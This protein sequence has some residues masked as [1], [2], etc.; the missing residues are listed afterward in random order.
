MY[1]SWVHNRAVD[2]NVFVCIKMRWW[3]KR[4]KDIISRVIKK[5]DIIWQK[6]MRYSFDV[7]SSFYCEYLLVQK[8]GL[9][10]MNDSVTIEEEYLIQKRPVSA[11][12]FGYSF[13]FLWFKFFM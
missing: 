9:C 7:I 8:N 1:C 3:A 5:S 11:F 12:F 2:L 13:N 10:T 4:E 6:S